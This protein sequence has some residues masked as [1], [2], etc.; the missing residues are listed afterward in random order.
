M[1]AS[2]IPALCINAGGKRKKTQQRTSLL[3]GGG[4]GRGEEEGEGGGKGVG[5]GKTSHTNLQI[6]ER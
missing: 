5:Q 6:G 2:L 1:K 4:V 3:M